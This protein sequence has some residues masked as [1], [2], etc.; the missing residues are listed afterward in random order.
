M[1]CLEKRP[2]V[3]VHSETSLR[4]VHGVFRKSF[5]VAELAVDRRAPAQTGRE[6]HLVV[7]RTII[8]LGCFTRRR[9]GL[10][11]CDGGVTGELR[12]A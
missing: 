12:A 9:T 7:V 11:C 3:F 2:Q 1:R 5:D 4:A 6:G 8:P 10:C